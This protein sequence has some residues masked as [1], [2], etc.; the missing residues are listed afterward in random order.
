[1]RELILNVFQ[2][3]RLII[4][5]T[6]VLLFALVLV[7]QRVYL[8]KLEDR[9]ATNGEFLTSLKDQNNE[10]E[11]DIVRISETKE[12]ERIAEMDFGLRSATLNE[13]V[14]LAE[15]FV[16]EEIEKSFF[17]NDFF[18]RARRKIDGLVVGAF[19]LNS[20]EIGGSI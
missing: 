14:V 15:P 20:E 11:R 16:H 6:F 3:L 19:E 18:A 8:I 5:W 17:L 12:L 10:L 13:V 9:L 4:I 7:A 2:N 1:M